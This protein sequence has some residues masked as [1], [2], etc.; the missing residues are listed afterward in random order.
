MKQTGI[1]MLLLMAFVIG[2]TPSVNGQTLPNASQF[3]GA[4][5]PLPYYQPISNN[6]FKEFPGCI[7][8]AL[9]PNAKSPVE[10]LKFLRSVYGAGH[11]FPKPED[12]A[13]C[14]DNGFHSVG[15]ALDWAFPSEE[16]ANAVV[17]WLTASYNGESAAMARRLGIVQIIY[18]PNPAKQYGNYGLW[19]GFSGTAPFWKNKDVRD[20]GD[21]VHFSFGERSADLNTSFWQ[22]F[23][24]PTGPPTPATIANGTY[25]LRLASNKVLDAD[26]NTGKVQ[27]WDGGANP[28][29]Q[30]IITTMG[31]GKYTL[32]LKA[33]AKALDLNASNT[34]NDGAITL[35]GLNNP[36]SPNQQWIISNAGN[37]YYKIH[38]SLAP[39]GVVDVELNDVATNG[40]K[41]HLWEFLGTSN[42]LWKIEPV[43]VTPPPPP[44]T[45]G[46][47]TGQLTIGQQLNPGNALQSPNGKHILYYQTDGNLVIYRSGV[48]IWHS[49]TNGQP[50]GTCSMQAD[51]NLVIYKSAGAAIWATG[52]NTCQ[53]NSLAMQD[54]GNLVLYTASGKAV[55]ATGTNG[56]QTNMGSAT[57][58]KLCN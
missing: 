39:Y 23:N 17:D 34:K 33:N 7:N 35:W 21:H 20:H 58:N 46:I 18:T 14:G 47:F 22:Q 56:G 6:P 4:V 2:F 1:L 29:Q 41:V 25:V 26:I 27:I 44:P 5:D 52:T 57:G 15:K 38:T 55:W 12:I 54:D 53:A 50:A 9:P 42:Q 11:K 51:G 10:F 19:Q 49:H 36:V 28:N 37:G 8:G 43:V 3:T 13:R 48:A 45:P 16:A 32:T 24:K 31:A 40:R 30:W